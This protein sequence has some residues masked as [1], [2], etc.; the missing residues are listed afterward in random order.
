VG[1]RGNTLRLRAGIVCALLL[2]CVM[3]LGLVAPSCGRGRLQAAHEIGGLETAAP[4]T[5]AELD[6]LACPGGVDI[7]LW[8]EL[9]DALEE[10]LL[11]QEESR[12]SSR[13]S[14]FKESR[15]ENRDS[16]SDMARSVSTPPTG[17]ANQVND[18]A[19]A[20][21]GDGTYTLTWHYRNLGDYDQN[22]AVS[23]SDIT[24][25]A[26]H[27][28]EA[29]AAGEENSLPSVIDGSGNGRVG[30]EDITPIAV[31][32]GVK[33]D[34]YTIEGA[35]EQDGP[36]ESASDVAQSAGSGDRRLAYEHILSD[37]PHRWYRV[38]PYDSDEVSGEPSESALSP[39]FQEWVHTWGGSGYEAVCETAP[40]RIG[41]TYV[42]GC[43]TTWGAGN[44]DFLLL[45]YGS[46]G[47][48][49]WQKTWG[50]VRMDV[51][52]SVVVD[53]NEGIYVTGYS[54]G[55]GAGGDDMILLKYAKS[56]DLLW[57]QTWGGSEDDI[58]N[59]I[60]E[61]GSGFVY[62]TGYTSSFGAGGRD[63]ILLKYGPDG[64][65]LR[66]T[67]YG[68]EGDDQG[69]A[70][71]Y[72]KRGN[73]YVTGYTD[74]ESSAGGWANVLLLKYDLSGYLVWRKTWGTT[75][76]DYGVATALDQAGN[77][78]VAGYTGDFGGHPY[79]LIVLKYDD[80]GNLVWQRTWGEE[81]IHCTGHGVVVDASS[82]VYVT[83]H[84]GT[85]W[86]PSE[87][88]YHAVLLKFDS[89]GSLLWQRSWY[90][91]EIAHGYNLTLDESG[92]VYLV[93]GALNSGGFWVEAS[94]VITTPPGDVTMP[95][96][97][98]ASPTGSETVPDGISASPVGIVDVGAGGSDALI[99]K[100]DPS[101]W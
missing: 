75:K 47:T 92:M 45:K 82:N 26:Q 42:A 89:N 4:N 18:L 70:L 61:D 38:V 56:G 66:Q 36:W 72:D 67:I 28:G 57:Q 22:G 78:Y 16:F 95:D 3:A 53:R 10:A 86:T 81:G 99:M 21:N 69:N 71:V 5:F 80:E 41:D 97:W 64:R 84:A 24:P 58:S 94:G 1:A 74:T 13:D 46:S 30:I 40:D 90:S 20:D 88:N 68:T 54:D 50:G 62:V 8:A 83:G 101:R 23:I 15:L 91:G 32:I 12:L 29:W 85:G 59:D 43:T 7:A 100:I 31:N 37:A 51:A 48:P 63:L 77:V 65:L 93:G 55:F 2:A 98:I 17:E 9:K 87:E 73:L 27:F 6:A 52:H 60:A 96:C 76:W 19:I 33:V 39:L 44:W 14:E 34:H 35:A 79:E 49:L 11:S 25:I